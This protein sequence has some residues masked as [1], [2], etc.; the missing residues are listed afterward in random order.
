[1]GKNREARTWAAGGRRLCRAAHLNL[2][3]YPY[4]R[5]ARAL[6]GRVLAHDVRLDQLAGEVCNI[7]LLLLYIWR[8]EV[9]ERAQAAVVAAGGTYAA[10]LCCEHGKGGGA[11]RSDVGR[12]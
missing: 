7:A 8:L 12:A 11:R 9:G 6:A 10:R 4:R 3:L 1:M 5:G 2:R